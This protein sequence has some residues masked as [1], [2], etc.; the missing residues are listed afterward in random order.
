MIIPV[1]MACVLAK[2]VVGD[3]YLVDILDLKD[4]YG[5]V[6]IAYDP[7]EHG[8]ISRSQA[9]KDF[10]ITGWTS[11]NKRTGQIRDV[12]SVEYFSKNSRAGIKHLDSFRLGGAKE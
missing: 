2:K 10:M 5:F 11:V 12:S 7:E 3:L 9:Y 1:D 4:S 8:P 6:F